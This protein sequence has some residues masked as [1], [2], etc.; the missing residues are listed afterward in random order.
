MKG[1]PVPV[2]VYPEKAAGGLFAPI[3]DIAHF[4]IAGM[5]DSYHADHDVLKPES[6]E[7]IYTPMAEITGFYALVSKSY[8]FGHFVENT[9]NG[10]KAVWH[11]GQGD[12]WMTHFHSIPEDNSG[13]VI[14][15]NSSRSW[16]FISYI[17]SDWAEWGGFSSVG[18]GIIAKA[19]KVIWAVIGLIVFAS[20]WQAWQLGRGIVSGRRQFSPLS[21]KSRTLRLVQSGI[22]LIVV[23]ALLWSTN[24]EYSFV[25]AV[26]PIAFGWLE[27]SIFIFAA[28]LLLSASFPRITV[29]VK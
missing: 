19:I 9:P 28:V 21:K 22:F 20:L 8:G 4:V 7:R 12:G 27:L 18:F 17:L 3:E 15:T 25:S 23:S 29:E 5:P 1:Q 2:H 16:P 11:G 26:F 10:K 14:I 6:I 24:Q 13:I